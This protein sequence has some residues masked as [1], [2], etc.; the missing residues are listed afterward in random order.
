[1][2]AF[3]PGIMMTQIREHLINKE[4]KAQTAGKTDPAEAWTA[5][6]KRYGDKEI[7]LVNVP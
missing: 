7:A 3:P 4:A 1:M 6:D 2:Q 5:L